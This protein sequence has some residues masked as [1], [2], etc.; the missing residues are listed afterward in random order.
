MKEI[1]DDN[2]DNISDYNINYYEELDL[3]KK[4]REKNISLS[5]ENKDL[6]NE[7]IKIENIVSFNNKN[8]NNNNMISQEKVKLKKLVN[9]NSLMVYKILNDI[10][11]ISSLNNKIENLN[12]IYDSIKINTL[13]Y[14]NKN[15]KYQKDIMDIKKIEIK[16]KYNNLNIS[17]NYAL[18]K[19]KNAQEIKQTYE[20]IIETLKFKNNYINNEKEANAKIDF[21]LNQ[22]QKL[23]ENKINLINI[24]NKSENTK[25]KNEKMNNFGEK[26]NNE[27]INILKIKN[28]NLKEK[29]NKY[30]N[31]IKNLNLSMNNNSYNFDNGIDMKILEANKVNDK[32]NK[33]IENIINKYKK[34]INQKNLLINQLKNKYIALKKNDISSMDNL[35]L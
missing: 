11:D 17:Y 6:K 23:I 18:K 33:N 3:E 12:P 16:N 34:E 2:F 24:I 25:E 22:K 10:K 8:L 31:I 9:N 1:Y 28:K 5:K 7:N 26:Y 13:I 4:F 32:I 35:I 20:N 14:D 27:D 15:L 30:D 21:L 29:L 19:K